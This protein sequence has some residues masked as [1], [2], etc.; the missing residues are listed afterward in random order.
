MYV[1]ER[2]ER[3]GPLLTVETVVK[4]DS[5]S[6]NERVSSLVGSLGLI[7]PVQETFV[8]PWLL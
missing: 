7:V 3:G 5:K 2:L 4:G 8:L 6:T 1:P